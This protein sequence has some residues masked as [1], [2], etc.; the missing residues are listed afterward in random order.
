MATV[1]KLGPADHGRPMAY[2]D[3]MAGDYELGYKYEI[4]DGKLYV[5]PLPNAPEE[6]VEGWI[7]RKLD[8]YSER[9]PDVLNYVSGKSRVFVSGRPGVTVP[10]PDVSAYRD[11]P[12]DL[13]SDEL[14][15]QD[16]RPCLVVEVLTGENPDKDLVRNVEL[17]LLVPS[18]KEYWV[19]D[20]RESAD[21]PTMIAFRRSGKRWVRKDVAF[22]ETYTTRLLPDFELLL[23]PRRR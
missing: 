9:R 3:F 8:R 14:R 10:E 12:F 17:Y 16:L 19:I 11:Y 1:T 21:R 22:G 20:S 5:S 23:D 6:R 15:W 7:F 4:I 13:P 18:I 2:D